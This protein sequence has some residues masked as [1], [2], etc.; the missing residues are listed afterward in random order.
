M[1]ATGTNPARIDPAFPN[2]ACTN[3][4]SPRTAPR[5]G[6]DAGTLMLRALRTHALA[7]GVVVAV[8]RID[9]RPWAS[10]TFAGM[11]HDVTVEAGVG[12]ALAAWLAALPDADWALRGH[13]VADVVVERTTTQSDG[14]VVSIGV[15]TIEDN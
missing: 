4:V 8:L 6:P 12:D 1:T 10:A 2:N 11:R 14:N 7:A 13:L 3:M 5:R 15:L 9:S